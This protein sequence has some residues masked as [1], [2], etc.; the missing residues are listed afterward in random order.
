MSE[1]PHAD[2][3]RT[4]IGALYE[5]ANELGPGYGERVHTRALQIVLIEKGLKA[6]IDVRI[7]VFFRRKLVGRF[8]ADMIV[9][10]TVLLEIKR[11]PELEPK[12]DAQILNY[13]TCAGGGIGLL[14]NFGAS[15]TFRRF[16]KGD[17]TN[18]LPKLRE[19]RCAPGR[20]SDSQQRKTR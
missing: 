8:F 7:R 17:L 13:L 20:E 1:L 16:A 12:D 5:T 11:K 9:N 19:R 18:C 3:T 4:I 6:E 15:V 14:V 2:L 10:D